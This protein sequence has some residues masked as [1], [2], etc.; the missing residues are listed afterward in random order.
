M[1][2]LREGEEGKGID[3]PPGEGRGFEWRGEEVESLGG[4]EDKYAIEPGTRVWRTRT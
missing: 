3:L 2:T 1:R 4:T